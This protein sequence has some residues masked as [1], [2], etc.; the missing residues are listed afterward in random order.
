MEIPY[1]QEGHV[2]LV[3]V[4]LKT[5]VMYVY[6][7]TERFYYGSNILKKLSKNFVLIGVLVHFIGS[8]LN[9]KNAIVVEI[10]SNQWVPLENICVIV[11]KYPSLALVEIFQKAGSSSIQKK[12]TTNNLDKLQQKTVY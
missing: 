12:T 4:Q 1:G 6:H 9:Q 3:N 5:Y 8:I 11:N 10:D 2:V 7:I